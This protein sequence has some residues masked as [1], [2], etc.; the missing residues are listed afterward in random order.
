LH[1]SSCGWNSCVE[2]RIYKSFFVQ[3][4]CTALGVSHCVVQLDSRR[5]GHT[6]KG[7]VTCQI[8]HKFLPTF[9][10]CAAESRERIAT[11][12]RLCVAEHRLS[13]DHT[14][15]GIPFLYRKPVSN[16]NDKSSLLHTAH[17]KQPKVLAA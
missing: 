12:T 7:W 16:A 15:R 6:E 8:W 1:V 3:N 4:I 11:T 13:I 10:S 2:E 14:G 5:S 17:A 9:W